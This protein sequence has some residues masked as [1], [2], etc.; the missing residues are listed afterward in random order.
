MNG[1]E[2]WLWLLVGLT[3]YYLKRVNRPGKLHRL[4]MRALFWSL[5]VQRQSGGRYE[6][7]IRAPL[8]ER[9]REAMWAAILRLREP[10]A[11]PED[12]PSE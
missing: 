2:I 3:P 1:N 9:L 4:E 10:E 8:I 6:W 5:V 12:E 11:S 7:T